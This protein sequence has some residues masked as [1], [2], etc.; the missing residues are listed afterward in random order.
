MRLPELLRRVEGSKAFRELGRR[1][2]Y[3]AHVFSMHAPRQEREYQLGYYVPAS[4]GI[5][6]FTARGE[7]LPEERPFTAGEGRIKPLEAARVRVT[8]GE[9]EEKALSLLE[10]KHPGEEV[11]KVIMILQH[12]NRQLYNVTLVTRSLLLVNARLDAA[13]GELLSYEEHS[14]LSL[15]R[16]E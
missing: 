6:V 5:I 13:T 12:L 3:L 14:L 16:K 9:A 11:T 2:C 8:F 1:K 7:R 4:G 15:W 10:R